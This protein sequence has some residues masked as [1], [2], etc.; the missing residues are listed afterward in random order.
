MIDILSESSYK[1]G[2]ANE[3][4]DV[5]ELVFNLDTGGVRR[6]DGSDAR[7]DGVAVFPKTGDAISEDEDDATYGV[8]VASEDDRVAYGAN[9][10]SDR[11]NALTIEDGGQGNSAP[12]IEHG[13]VVG[14]VDPT[15]ADAPDGVKGRVVEEGYSADIDGDG[16]AT[17]FN[18]SNG[19]FLPL[20][21]AYKDSATSFDTLVEVERRTDL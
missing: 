2:V 16:A 10:Q 15:N 20:G 8:Y 6:A 1:S 18:R 7:I 4:I 11:F 17:T 21:L 9:T 12:S 13:T 19:N 5:G 3:D 14:L